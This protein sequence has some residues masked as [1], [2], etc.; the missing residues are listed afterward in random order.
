M[1]PTT[2]ASTTER[3]EHKPAVYMQRSRAE[4]K[5]CSLWLRNH[6]PGPW[7]AERHTTVAASVLLPHQARAASCG[8]QTTAVAGTLCL[9]T[10]TGRG[11]GAVPNGNP[12]KP[13]P[14]MMSHPA[15]RIVLK[16]T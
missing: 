11:R 13:A 2:D 16:S 4:L 6:R 5:K 9:S 7:A 15:L 1:D 8:A 14:A 10:T 3:R 12:A